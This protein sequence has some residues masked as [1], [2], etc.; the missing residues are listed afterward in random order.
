[1]GKRFKIR[2]KT[3]DENIAKISHTRII[4]DRT[5][6][7]AFCCSFFLI[8]YFIWSRDVID[9][10]PNTLSFAIVYETLMRRRYSDTGRP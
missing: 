10:K 8:F 4:S 6:R 3:F 7:S 1:V 5:R 9:Y 2:L